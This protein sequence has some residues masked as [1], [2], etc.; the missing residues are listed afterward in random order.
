MAFQGSTRQL[1]AGRSKKRCP[2]LCSSGDK[3]RN[4]P[5]NHHDPHS[6]MVMTMAMMMAMM[7]TMMMAKMMMKMMTMTSWC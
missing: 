3:A 2:V 7:M 4:R 5:M 1:N 6:K